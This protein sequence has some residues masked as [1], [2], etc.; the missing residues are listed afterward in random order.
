MKKE[1]TVLPSR[2]CSRWAN[3]D[4]KAQSSTIVKGESS[5]RLIVENRYYRSIDILEYT[6]NTA[7]R[8][9]RAVNDACVYASGSW[10]RANSTHGQ[11]RECNRV[12]SVTCFI[13]R[14]KVREHATCCLLSDFDSETFEIRS[15]NF[16]RS[17]NFFPSKA[18]AFKKK[19]M[20][21]VLKFTMKK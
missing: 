14:K 2:W 15:A 12:A 17:D 8:R 21:P 5:V 9:K 10:P 3:A 19:E 4:E 18:S 20:C 6:L 16:S 11:F 13:D 7:S 1:T